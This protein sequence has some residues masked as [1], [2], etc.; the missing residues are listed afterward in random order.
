MSQLLSWMNMMAGLILFFSMSGISSWVM[1]STPQ[2]KIF[3]FMLGIL[4]LGNAAYL[5]LG[6]GEFLSR[7]A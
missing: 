1:F 5:A 3:P 4:L 6:R 2:A 7:R